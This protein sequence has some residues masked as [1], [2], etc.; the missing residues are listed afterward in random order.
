MIRGYCENCNKLVDYYTKETE[1]TENIKGKEYKYL[2]IKGY[3]KICNNEISANDLLDKNIERLD[4]VY[5]K[6]E[7]L[8][9]TKEINEI[10]LKYKIGKKPL[11]K[12]LDW[13]EVTLIRYLNGFVPSKVYSDE[14]YKILNDKKYMLQLLEKNKDKITERAYKNVLET[15]R[16]TKELSQI[17]LCAEYILNKGTD[18]TQLALEKLLYYSQG[19]Y[20]A[21]IGEYLFEDDCQAWIYGPV[22]KEVYNIYKE[23][24]SDK[25]DLNVEY[26]FNDIIDEDKRKVLDAV[27][28]YFGCYS[29]SFLVDFTHMEDP[30]KKCRKGLDENERSN[31]IISKDSIYKYFEKIKD[32]YKMIDAEDIKKYSFAQ[33][34]KV[35]G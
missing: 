2:A 20:K 1:T 7:G 22:Y 32:E 14:L 27:I 8:I 26:D 12:L 3:C 16:K 31:I 10:L 24:G 35:M 33:F 13:G 11:A 4:E 21:F 9:T 5:R 15:I 6:T 18:I 25:I 19:F 28:K 34:E 29:G 23:Y 17:E 30:W